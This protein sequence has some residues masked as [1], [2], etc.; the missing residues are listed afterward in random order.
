MRRD[1]YFQKLHPDAVAPQ[2]AHDSDSG[3]DLFSV[4]EAWIEPGEYRLVSTGLAIKLP[5]GYE[6]QVR[7][8]SGLAA[9]Y[10]ISVLNSPGTID[11]GYTGEIK[12]ILHNAGK[13]PY[14]VERLSKIAQIV[15]APYEQTTFNWHEHLPP[16]D[17]GG[18]GFGSTGN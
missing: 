15:I 2:Y 3:A 11:N 10:G 7:S 8:K 12:V 17:R 18:A 5:E 4:E 1:T 6:A 16:T 13:I 14:K 9:K